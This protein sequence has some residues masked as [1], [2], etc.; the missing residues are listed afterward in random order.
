MY[1]NT[2]QKKLKIKC[3]ANISI[4]KVLMHPQTTAWKN[5]ISVNVIIITYII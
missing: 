5:L 3:R 4:S 2:K 1:D